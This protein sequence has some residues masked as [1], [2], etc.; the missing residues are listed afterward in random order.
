MAQI[1]TDEAK[2]TLFKQFCAISLGNLQRQTL[3]SKR[4]VPEWVVLRTFNSIIEF[5]NQLEVS[6]NSSMANMLQSILG[7]GTPP[8]PQE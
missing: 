1:I 4:P 2:L 7:T 6:D 8:A 3:L 5:G